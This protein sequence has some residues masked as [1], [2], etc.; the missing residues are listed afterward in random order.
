[1]RETQE[2]GITPPN[3]PNHQVKY[4]LKVKRKKDI[5]E[6]EPVAGIRKSIVNKGQ[7]VMQ[8]SIGCLHG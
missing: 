1:M 8:V 2:N 5:G 3:G 4:H 7:A 6:R